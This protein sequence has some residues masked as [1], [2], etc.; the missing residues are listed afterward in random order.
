MVQ[1]LQRQFLIITMMPNMIQLIETAQDLKI[2]EEPY[3][4]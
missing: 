3:M 4:K 2:I 1:N